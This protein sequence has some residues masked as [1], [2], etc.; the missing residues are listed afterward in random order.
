[1]SQKKI[2]A[3]EKRIEHLES[4]IQAYGFADSH[5][6]REEILSSILEKELA[7]SCIK[8]E[9]SLTEWA[10]LRKRIL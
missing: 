3:L 9:L 6:Y 4:V 2:E 5:Y 1:M 7:T 8:K 10:E